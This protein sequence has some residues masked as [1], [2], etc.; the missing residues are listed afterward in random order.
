[1]SVNHCYCRPHAGHQFGPA[2]LASNLYP[3][4]LVQIRNTQIAARRALTLFTGLARTT[5]AA[6]PIELIFFARA[7]T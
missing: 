3:L 2:A 6:I 7:S 1:M 5:A 4:S